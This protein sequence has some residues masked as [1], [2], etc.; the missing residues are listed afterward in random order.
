ML[1]SEHMYC[2]DIACKMTERVEQWIWIKFCVKLEHSSMET[3]QM[4]QKAAAMGNWWL[5]SS[6]WQ[7]VPS[8]ITSH[9]EVFGKTSN[10]P[11][12]SAPLQSRFGTPR[13]LAFPKTK[14]TFEREEISDCWWDSGK[15]NRAADGDWENCVRCQGTY[16]EGD[17]G[18]IVLCTMFLVSSSINVSIFH[19]T[20]LDMFWTDLIFFWISISGFLG[21]IARSG[22]AGLKDSYIFKFLRNSIPF[23]TVSAPVCISSHSSWGG[24]SETYFMQEL[25][26]F[27]CTRHSRR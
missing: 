7:N 19:M 13:L 10:H 3:I 5:A 27:C 16:F 6:S 25:F 20:W 4:I 1:L 12:D 11:G 9:T 23:S 14:I 18:V 15:Y 22:I 24:L 21:Y 17:W 2:V 8:C 26:A